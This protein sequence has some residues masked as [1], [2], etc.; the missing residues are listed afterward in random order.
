MWKM[1]ADYQRIIKSIKI[2][3]IANLEFYSIEKDRYLQPISDAEMKHSD[4]IRNIFW[5]NACR[6]F[7]LSC[8]E[9][10]AY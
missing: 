1:T 8:L 4:W 6:L 9:F 2:Q 3:K 7:E 5:A 10:M